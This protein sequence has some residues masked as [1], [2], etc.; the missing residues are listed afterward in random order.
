MDLVLIV[1][2]V[3]CMSF[4]NRFFYVNYF[5]SFPTIHSYVYAH[6]PL[7]DQYYYSSFKGSIFSP[8]LVEE[9]WYILRPNIPQGILTCSS[10]STYA[11]HSCVDHCS[12]GKSL[13][14]YGSRALFLEGL[15]HQMVWS[16]IGIF[17]WGDPL[18][19]QISITVKKWC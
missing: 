11:L 3:R 14:T 16:L 10:E 2:K 15:P 5:A 9:P 1:L 12:Q 19:W 6:V 7:L 4:N 13:R 17:H 8:L 18:S